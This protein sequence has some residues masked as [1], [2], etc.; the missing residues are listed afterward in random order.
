M[1]V[2][3]KLTISMKN[4]EWNKVY[5]LILYPQSNKIVE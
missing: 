5:Y 4:F 1:L 2:E 3:E